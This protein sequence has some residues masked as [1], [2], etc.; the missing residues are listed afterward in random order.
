MES[1][2]PAPYG[3]LACPNSEAL[4][5]FLVPAAVDAEF[6][7]C[8]SLIK[9]NIYHIYKYLPRHKSQYS[10]QAAVSQ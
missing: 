1:K 7:T 3:H 9:M 10:T 5:Y 2:P 6:Q 8:A 4:K